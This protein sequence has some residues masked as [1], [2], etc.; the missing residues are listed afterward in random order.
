MPR[1][2]DRR[3][4]LLVPVEEPAAKDR[5]RDILE[6][7]LDDNVKGGSS[8]PDGGYK[9]AVAEEEIARPQPGG[10]LQGRVRRRQ[11]G[12]PLATDDAGTAPRAGQ[13]E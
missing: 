2:L 8:F 12:R 11:A 13:E 4:E 9:R 7:C 5:L 6:W 3:V 1:N 10:P